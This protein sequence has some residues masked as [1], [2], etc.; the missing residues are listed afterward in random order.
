MSNQS[1]SS[2]QSVW[3]RSHAK[4]IGRPGWI[5]PERERLLL[6]EFMW[7]TWFSF[8]PSDQ[9]GLHVEGGDDVRGAIFLR[10]ESYPAI[11]ALVTIMFVLDGLFAMRKFP[12]SRGSAVKAR[13]DASRKPG[14]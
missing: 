10:Q 9:Q 3:I 14:S 4:A 5:C 6:G 2:P 8:P 11:V 7:G 12:A 13:L 1:T